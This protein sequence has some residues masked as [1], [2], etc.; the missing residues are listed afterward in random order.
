[1]NDPTQDPSD[2]NVSNTYDNEITCTDSS[3]DTSAVGQ[4]FKSCLSCLRNST[5]SGSGESDQSWFLYNLRFALDSCLFGF[6]N[7]TDQLK[8][9][10]CSTSYSCGPLQT[11]LEDG[12]LVP[13]NGSE[14]SYCSADGNAV[15]GSALSVC[16]N[17]LQETPDE[18]YLAN[19]LT[20]VQAGCSQRP[21]SSLVIG[22]QGSLFATTPVNATFPGDNGSHPKHKGLAQG[23]IIGIVVGSVAAVIICSVI[24]FICRRKA[25]NRKNMKQLRSPLDPRF[26]APNITAPN[27]GS[28]TTPSTSPGFVVKQYRGSVLTTKEM[29]AL[30]GGYAF[31]EQ[32]PNSFID[33]HAHRE[34]TLPGYSPAQIPTHQAY[35][36]H[37]GPTSPAS[38]NLINENAYQLDTYG[39]P[40]SSPKN[41]PG[42][43]PTTATTSTASTPNFDL[44]HPPRSISRNRYTKSEPKYSPA[45]LITPSTIYRS[46]TPNVQ[47]ARS[48]PGWNS[49]P[50]GTSQPP[51]PLP[52]TGQYTQ[53]N[54][55]ANPPQT[56]Q[57]VGRSI[58]MKGIFHKPNSS[59]A[60]PLVISGPLLKVEG[61]FE[62][63]LGDKERWEIEG[64]KME[65]MQHANA[66]TPQSAE[67][68]PEQWPGDY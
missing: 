33:A 65:E 64:Q 18:Q 2:P 15:M 25:H 3:F 30:N 55:S 34:G 62:S 16:R 29:D 46:V 60:P 41:Y 22:L 67:S 7:T 10:P 68:G 38:G 31:P 48:L 52:P 50:Q 27:D 28:F 26:G 23:A 56:A 5:A 44:G 45:P 9:S 1:M 36:P 54:E 12:N 35:I 8:D 59:K 47:T 39:S 13:G 51:P 17:C 43:I 42:S 4:K 11:A 20:A 57:K 19:F 14:F 49:T 32:S 66:K 21:S 37:T 58:S 63:D 24:F 53:A 61:R 6:P 40:E